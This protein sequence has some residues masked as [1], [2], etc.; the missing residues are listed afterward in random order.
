MR[1]LTLDAAALG[2]SARRRARHTAAAPAVAAPAARRSRKAAVPRAQSSPASQ[3]ADAPKLEMDLDEARQKM[4]QPKYGGEGA[5]EWNAAICTASQ[6]V[7]PDT[8]VVTLNVRAR[9]L[10]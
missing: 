3:E 6:L 1:C 5:P 9:G 4:Y 2:C 8:R 10:S 7:L